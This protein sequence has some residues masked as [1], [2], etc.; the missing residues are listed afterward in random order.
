MGKQ[1]AICFDKGGA[2]IFRYAEFAEKRSLAM[3]CDCY[4]MNV[5][6]DGDIWLNYYTD[7]PLVQ[8]RD[9][10]LEQVRQPFRHMGNAFAIRGPEVLYL[11]RGRFLNAS[12]N[13]SRES[14]IVEAVNEQ[15]SDLSLNADV[16]LDASA[17][18]SSFVVNTGTA[19]YET[20]G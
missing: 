8:L 11:E 3:I 6:P 9:F 10:N 20:V 15:G 1:G 12:L 17:R 4:A 2:S 19:V 16:R 5:A 14:Q 7:F 18:G 13:S